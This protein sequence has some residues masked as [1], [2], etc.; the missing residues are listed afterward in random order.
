VIDSLKLV[1]DS[2][3]PKMHF[4]TISE[5][6]RH[7]CDDRFA[8]RDSGSR[9][10]SRAWRRAYNDGRPYTSLGWLIP[11][12]YAVAAAKIAPNKFRILTLSL[13]ETPGGALNLPGLTRK[14]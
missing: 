9:R 8:H 7:I 4:V 14:I 1:A 2:L 12:E 11:I 10:R 6:A 5:S 13:Y 3:R